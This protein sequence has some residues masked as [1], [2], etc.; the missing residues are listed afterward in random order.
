MIRAPPQ[1][2][3]GGKPQTGAPHAAGLRSLAELTAEYQR[4]R[5]GSGANSAHTQGAPGQRKEPDLSGIAGGNRRRGGKRCPEAAAEGSHAPSGADAGAALLRMIKPTPAAAPGKPQLCGP[6]VQHGPTGTEAKAAL[7]GWMGWSP[8]PPK[9][10]GYGGTPMYITSGPALGLPQ[11]AAEPPAVQSWF[12]GKDSHLAEICVAEAMMVHA[13]ASLLSLRPRPGPRPKVVPS[14]LAL[15]REVDDHDSYWRCRESGDVAYAGGWGQDERARLEETFGPLPSEPGWLHE[16]KGGAGAG[17]HGKDLLA[18]EDEDED[19]EQVA[20]DVPESKGF[21]KWFAPR[22]QSSSTSTPFTPP[23][24]A[25]TSTDAGSGIDESSDEQAF[26]LESHLDGI[27]V[28]IPDRDLP[29]ARATSFGS[30]A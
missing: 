19:E 29:R 24:E 5:V 20:G 18:W 17:G 4:K 28:E 23:L 6:E 11:T 22:Q 30:S 7:M 14:V 21:S 15:P 13:R 10:N 27:C 1:G 16:A 8:S 9:E 26:Q 2:S 25:V 3:A 12:A